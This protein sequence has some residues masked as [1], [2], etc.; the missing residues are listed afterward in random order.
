MDGAPARR[1]VN[2]ILA[3]AGGADTVELEAT[4]VTALLGPFGIRE[5]E[6]DAEA[7]RALRI[8]IH[9]PGYGRYDLGPEHPFSPVRG[10]MLLD[11]LERLGIQVE[12]VQ[13][14]PLAVEEPAAVHTREYVEAVEAASSG[15]ELEDLERWGLGTADNPV[16]PGIAE[17][18][19]HIA[20]GTVLGARLLTGGR[21]TKV[22][23]LGGGLHH[24]RPALASGFCLYNDLAL[25]I[26]HMVEHG[27][28]V[29][30]PD[31]D[32]HH[33]DGVQE[34]FYGHDRVMTISLH[35]T[36]EYLF[37]GTGWLHELGRGMGRGLKLN[38]PLEP[39][40]EGDT[41]REV[42]LEAADSA[43][44]WFRPDALV[45]Q[46]GADAH[47]SDPLADLML[48]TRDF[49]RIYRD[50]LE[51]ADRTAGGRVLFT[52]GGEYSLTATPRIWAIL[53]LVL[54]DLQI[55]ERLPETWR[56]RWQEELG[57]ELPET[58]H[59]PEDAYPPIPRRP[60]IVHND[61]DLLRRLLDSAAPIWL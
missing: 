19:R 5:N 58:L 21:A 30:Y 1:L 38:L 14:E 39:F 45:V 22:L 59:D 57:L 12:P 41:Y 6:R 9:H 15:R 33:G 26:H 18:A 20:G 8:R 27:W 10:R 4:Y 7:G 47:F 55:P 32:V 56:R 34:I 53:Y 16:V 50:V 25:A 2:E 3:S 52:L 49:E 46:A 28:H 40:T 61:R 13:P 36:G 31:L 42:L 51:L 35:E 60:E 44:T 48:T 23:H 43:L 17:G 37:P 54:H 11:L 29:A 24:A